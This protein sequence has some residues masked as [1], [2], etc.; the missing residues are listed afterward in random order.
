MPDRQPAPVEFEGPVRRAAPV[1]IAML[2]AAAVAVALGLRTLDGGFIM[3]DDQRF[4]T[5][6]F[7][8]NHPSLAHAWKL[9]TVPHGDLYQP[10]P[11]LSFQLNYAMAASAG[12]TVSAYVFHATNVALHALCAMLVVWLAVSLT[13]RPLIAGLTGI[14]FAAH[15]MAL[16][17]VAWASGRMILLATLFSLI[18]FI[19]A[20]RRP[21]VPGPGWP[22]AIWLAWVGS[23]VSKVMPT[24]PLVAWMF[25]RISHR[26]GSRRGAWTYAA[27]FGIGLVAL[28]MMARLTHAEGFTAAVPDHP[29]D[30]LK[31]ML[32]AGGR[33][34]EQY[35]LP[36]RL[37]PWTPPVE[38]VAWSDPRVIRAAAALGALIAAAALLRRRVPVVSVGI[39]GFLL[40]LGP[41]LVASLAR[42]LFVADR[43]MYLPM[44]ALHLAVVAGAAALAARLAPGARAGR[45]DRWIAAPLAALAAWWL[46]IAIGLAPAWQDTVAYARRVVAIFPDHPD[47]HNELARAQLFM[48]QPADALRTARTAQARWPDA[49]RLFARVGEAHRALGDHAAALDAFDR[50]LAAHPDQ[51]RTR[52]LRALSLM[53][54]GR[55]RDAADA[56]EALNADVPSFLPAYRA[57]A[58]LYRESGDIERARDILTRAVELNPHHR[59]NLFDLAMIDFAHGRW[60]EAAHSLRRVLELSPADEPA[61]LNLAAALSRQDRHMEAVKLY[62]RLLRRNP[63]ATFA[64]FNRAELLLTMGQ[65]AAAE[66]DFQAILADDRDNIDAATRIHEI[67]FRRGDW[68]ALRRHWLNFGGGEAACYAL[69]VDMLAAFE[70]REP[71]PLP[72]RDGGPAGEPALVACVDWARIYA[73]LREQDWDGLRI[74]LAAGDS[75]T[76]GATTGPA[77]DALASLR[78]RQRRIWM[79]AFEA[80]PLEL[81]N[82]RPGM[83]VLA[84]LLRYFGDEELSGGI[85]AELARG[86]DA[87]ADHAAD[88]LKASDAPIPPAP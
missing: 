71:L 21:R 64:R 9:I 63:A 36:T 75:G 69:W 73:R 6:H 18:V 5:E 41:F 20:V 28:V 79:P 44:V 61:L 48:G 12:G 26:A 56:L 43:Y 42:R 83:L 7:L 85:A 50:L 77:A 8:V 33:Y 66:A 40:L 3:G 62:D 55:H 49:P 80:L 74:A 46:W 14:L 23:L 10:L 59:D 76:A 37:S 65:H 54:L 67:L 82:S 2:V 31:S 22:V 51:T 17:A 60:R 84:R 45:G 87:W 4:I 19:L 30:A 27:L 88:M 32:L 13:H 39:A 57:L 25:D 1:A 70:H 86:R 78:E 58:Q 68:E 15:P 29:A 16:E 52:Y 11:M 72:L 38:G 34:L 24:V 35:V 53:E 47:A 81:R